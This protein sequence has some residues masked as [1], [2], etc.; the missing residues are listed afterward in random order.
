MAM[1]T[2]LA[3]KN[4]AV[5]GQPNRAPKIKKVNKKIFKVNPVAIIMSII[6]I[7]VLLGY[8]VFSMVELNQVT[9][10]INN[11]DKQIRVLKSENVRLNAEAES[12]MNLSNIENYAKQKLGLT[13]LSPGQTTYISLSQG[14][15]IEIPQN[16]G[17]NWFIS[18]I[19]A[20]KNFFHI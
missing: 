5:K 4:T 7:A 12:M 13:K 15:S 3:Y 17:G 20:I 9:S 1:N 18:I 8:M 11:T 19:N 10:E 2:N 16:D 6:T 14:N